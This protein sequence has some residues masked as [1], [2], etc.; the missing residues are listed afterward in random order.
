VNGFLCHLT[1]ERFTESLFA[2]TIGFL[3]AAKGIL[4]RLSSGLYRTF[5]KRQFIY[6]VCKCFRRK[7]GEKDIFDHRHTSLFQKSGLYRHLN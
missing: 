1:I 6:C 3:K 4:K 7:A 5:R 2:V